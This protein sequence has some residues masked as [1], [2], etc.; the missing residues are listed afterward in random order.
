MTN[1]RQT[2]RLLGALPLA[3]A[4]A[5][6]TIATPSWA[7][8]SPWPKAGPIRFVVPFTAGSGTDVI[9]RVLAEKLGPAL[10]AQIVIDNRPGA[11]GTLGAA[12]VAKAP[13]DGY[14]F[15]IHSSGHVVNPALYPKLSYDTLGDLE[16]VT[17]LA[18]LPNVMV[19]APGRFRDVADLVAQA[20]AKPDGLQYASAGN[21]SATHMNAEQ[22]RL[23]AGLKALHVPFR[24]T[25]E[26]LTETIAGRVDW[27]FAP[28]VSALPLIKD[29]K[30]QA[31]A[32]GTATRST[33]LPQVPSVVEAGFKN[34]AYTFW[35]GL[36][37]PAK[38]PKAVV[39]RLHD[40]AMKALALPEVRERLD[41]LGAT[42]M[43]MEQQAF[44]R[45]LADETQA[46]AAL[47]KAAGMRID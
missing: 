9:A 47:V 14:T 31:L 34:A 20:R 2:L 40:E 37:A 28:L 5:T 44:S 10:G 27:F 36:F 32:V 1:R 15:L 46:A 45:Y 22:F 3:V 16:G 18:S 30:L 24:G 21:G 8:G 26:A 19:A 29:G 6:A 13:A 39:E 42:P 38:T 43:P 12:L 17:P 11:G 33:A 25:P 23:A 41:K 7:Q 4:A 35:V